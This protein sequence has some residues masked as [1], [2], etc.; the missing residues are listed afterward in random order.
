MRSLGLLLLVT[1]ICYVA[2][3]NAG[4][5]SLESHWEPPI[6]P[7]GP[8]V[9]IAAKKIRVP[10]PEGTVT[11]IIDPGHG[12]DDLGAKSTTMPVYSEKNFNLVTARFLQTSL[13]QLGHPTILTREKDVFVGLSQRAAI[14]TKPGSEIFVSVHFNAAQ[15]PDA[16]GIEVF[17]YDDK[18]DPT[19]TKASKALAQAI[20]TKVLA[21]THARSRGVK[22]GNYHVIRETAVPAI[23]IEGGFLTNPN[24]LAS[25]KDPTYLKKLAW[26]AA[27]GIDQYLK[28]R[29]L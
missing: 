19:R 28:A 25:I 17:Y 10:K 11:I 4:A 29:Q 15:S 6:A 14:A 3:G 7:L 27:Q 1:S 23:L 12:G 22:H 9:I 8:N 13:Q 18:K 21:A 26:G 20:F 16:E 2:I 5:S 24:E